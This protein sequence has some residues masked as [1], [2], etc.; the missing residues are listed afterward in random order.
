MERERERG[1]TVSLWNPTEP[2]SYRKRL[3][4]RRFITASFP[5]CRP[6]P[7]PRQVYNPCWPLTSRHNSWPSSCLSRQL[8][9]R[10]HLPHS[11]ARGP[12]KYDPQVFLWVSVWLACSTRPKDG[13][14][15]QNGTQNTSCFY[16]IPFIFSLFIYFFSH[17]SRIFLDVRECPAVLVAIPASSR[18]FLPSLHPKRRHQNAA[19]TLSIT[20]T[21]S[22]VLTWCTPP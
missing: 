7:R 2:Y 17:Y 10:C 1:S 16:S 5:L 9:S 18:C 11:P 19:H 12:H 8:C 13:E 21:V 14:G 3:T 4:L 22:M 20:L 15:G 6:H